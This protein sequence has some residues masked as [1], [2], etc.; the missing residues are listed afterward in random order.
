[1]PPNSTVNAPVTCLLGPITVGDTIP[2]PT[3]T[4][5][6]DVS[7]GDGTRCRGTAW[8]PATGRHVSWLRPRSRGG[9]AGRPGG[10]HLLREPG[11]NV[12]EA[13]AEPRPTRPAAGPPP[14]Y[15]RFLITSS[16]MGGTSSSAP[17]DSALDEKQQ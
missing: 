9:A 11:M 7:L 10:R 16:A 3:P 12:S 17:T 5:E 2:Q 14:R 13:E 4:L 1:M 6:L 15:R 8:L